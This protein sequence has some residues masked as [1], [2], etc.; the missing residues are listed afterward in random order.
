M[1][2]DYPDWQVFGRKMAE[3]NF[4]EKEQREFMLLQLPASER[5]KY[6]RN[7]FGELAE[8]IPQYQIASYLGITPESFNR[9]LKKEKA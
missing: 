4:I 3:E 2:E 1:M 7:R 9:L 6:F 8:Q 5:L